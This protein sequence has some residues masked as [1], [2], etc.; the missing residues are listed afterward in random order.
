LFSLGVKK[1]ALPLYIVEKAVQAVEITVLPK[2]PDIVRGVVNYKGQ[3]LPVIDIS[4]K[5]KLSFR[6]EKTGNSFIIVI[7]DSKK[8]ILIANEIEGIVEMP[9]ID[10]TSTDEIIEGINFVDG[11]LR[12][13][14]GL[15]LIPHLKKIMTAKEEITLKKASKTNE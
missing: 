13:N 9:E 5:F 6:E 12:L 3:I 2:A 14:D 8:F 11:V 15:I 10:E 7:T 4:K 1:F